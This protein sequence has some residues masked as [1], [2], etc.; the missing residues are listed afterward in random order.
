M[1]MSA[2]S[3]DVIVPA[4]N[5]QENIAA[6]LEAM[7][8]DHVRRVIVVDNGSTDDTATLAHE[9]GA[10]VVRER[11]RGYGS[12]CLAG[13]AHLAKDPPDIVA[14]IDAD[15]ADDPQLLPTLCAPIGQG[16]ADLVIG[17]R[18][19][20][21][22]PGSLTATQ[23]SGNGLACLLIRLFTGRRYLDLG[24]MRAIAWPALQKLHMADRT[25]GWTVEMQYK[26]AVQNLRTI[27]LHVPYRPR[28]AGQ[29][30]I[31]GTVIGSAKAGYKILS[32]IAVLWMTTR[33][34]ERRAK[35]ERRGATGDRREANGE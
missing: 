19:K 27:E 5:E 34:K 6:L 9:A 26:A 35:G 1:A 4:F 31:S 16:D 11:R 13:L 12:A 20:L 22:E 8:R 3:I 14:F 33:S 10:T 18:R 24:P 15:L 32:T 21:A 2:A 7:P 23:R 28:R 30:K 25:W 17:S 29:S